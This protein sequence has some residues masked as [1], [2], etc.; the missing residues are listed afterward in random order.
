M[1]GLEWLLLALVGY[2]LVTT[3][4]WLEAR[5]D[6][7]AERRRRSDAEYTCRWMAAQLDALDREVCNCSADSVSRDRG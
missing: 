3:L 4:A 5:L 7:R 2:G 1:T 6:W